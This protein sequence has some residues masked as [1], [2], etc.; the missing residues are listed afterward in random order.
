MSKSLTTIPLCQ[1]QRSKI[2]VRRTDRTVGIEQLAASIEAHGLLENLVVSPFGDAKGADAIYDV[3]AGGRR[4]AALKLLAKRKKI[5]S[6]FPVP[7]Q[8]RKPNGSSLVELSL[9]ENVE[10]VALHPADQFEAFARLQSEGQSAGAIAARFGLTQTLVVQRLK[11]AAV[12]PRLMAEYRKDAMTLEQL[13]AFTLSDDHVLQEEVWFNTGYSGMSPQEIRRHLTKAQVDG[14]DR[15]ARFVGIKAYEAAG[16]SIVRDLFDETDEGYFGDS[17]L[18]D[19]IVTVKLDVEVQIVRQEGWKWVESAVEVDYAQ[20]AR[21]A[22]A[23]TI[24]K[25][26]AAK[27]EKRLVRLGEKYDALVAEL[28]EDE[29]PQRMDQLDCVSAELKA[30]QAK[31]EDWAPEDKARSGAFLSLDRDGTLKIFRG[32]IKAEDV[33]GSD[34]SD[35]RDATSSAKRKPAGRYSEALLADMSAH[36][37]AALRELLASQPEHALTALLQTLVERFFHGGYQQGCIGI[38]PTF[39]E[40]ERHSKSVGEGKAALSFLDRHTQWQK[41]IPERDML[42]DWLTTLGGS[43][44]LA[45]LAHCVSATLDAV[46]RRD[47]AQEK[48]C[49]ADK[50]AQILSLNMAQWWR[51]TRANFLDAVSKGRIVQLVIEGVSAVEGNRIASLKKADMAEQAEA[52]LAATSWLPEPLRTI[53]VDTVRES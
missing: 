38:L 35:T 14:N 22:R 19:R 41:R 7:C 2:N 33:D 37:T 48:L 34:K 17:Q 4:H 30:L 27:D 50:L 51:P 46:W 29:G 45:L 23:K 10:R 12:S 20:L 15:R 13:M 8:V 44:R 18:L 24:E 28:E 36:R 53:S 3:L 25:V 5:A 31:K 32:L 26:L 9:A 42:W 1:L 47:V 40:L 11:L 43:D 39:P 49:E 52:V 16:G 21:F 6:D